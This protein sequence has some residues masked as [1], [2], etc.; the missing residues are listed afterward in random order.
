MTGQCSRSF[1]VKRG[2]GESLVGSVAVKTRLLSTDLTRL[3][4]AM[5][6]ICDVLFGITTFAGAD[7]PET[8]QQQRQPPPS[9]SASLHSGESTHGVCQL[10]GR[11][12]AD[13]ASPP[14]VERAARARRLCVATLPGRSTCR[15]YVAGESVQCRM[16]PCTEMC[17]HNCN[18]A[19]SLQR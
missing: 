2:K 6:A 14:L 8:Q 11:H 16:V 17:R 9:Y 7:S 3:F 1:N 4:V 18:C 5:S 15:L 13:P 19:G 12:C 10:A